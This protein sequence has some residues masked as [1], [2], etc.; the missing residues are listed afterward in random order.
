MIFAILSVNPAFEHHTG[1][2]AEDIVGRTVRELFPEAEPVWFERYGKV[3]LTGEPAHFEERFGPLN[4]WF[5]VSVYRTEPGRFAV[6]FFDISERKQA[7]ADV[8]KLSEDMAA[9]NLELETLNKELEAFIYSVSH[10]LRAPL[11]SMTGFAKI[12]QE[13]YADKLDD[14]AKDYLTRIFNGS[15]KMTQLINDL[16][17]LSK[18]S[19]QEVDRMDID[20]SKLAEAAIHNLREAEH[21]RNVEVLIAQGVRAAVDPNLMRVVLTNL[22]DNAWKFTSKTENAKIEFGAFECGMDRLGIADCGLRNEELKSEIANPK[23]A[24]R[25]PKWCTSCG[26]TAR[27]SIRPSLT[28]CSVPFSGC[29]WKMSLPAR[30]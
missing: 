5:E 4:K 10:D 15:T 27:G 26:T 22:L 8:L 21:G 28:R 24:I 12:M 20:L 6:V 16:L 25:D 17:H 7:E 18:L 19:R 3:V 14:Q 13:D 29:I 1:L 9:R 11:R 30:A 23:S 2:K